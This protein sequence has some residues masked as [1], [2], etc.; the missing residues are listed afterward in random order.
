M[1]EVNF[2]LA[3]QLRDARGKI[4]NRQLRREEGLIP[5]I[6]YGA[7]K[8][9]ASIT[10]THNKVMR[11]LQDEAFYSHIL[12]L[13]VSDKKEQVIL[14]DKRL[15]TLFEELRGETY[16]IKTPKGEKITINTPDDVLWL[17]L[18]SHP[19]ARFSFVRKLP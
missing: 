8:E 6:V 11:A 1:S 7:G 3:A 9:P 19:S 14:K 12:T 10:L 16:T 18:Y 17:L 5:A 2:E 13:N 15:M 4:K